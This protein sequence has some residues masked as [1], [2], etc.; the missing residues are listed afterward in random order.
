MPASGEVAEADAR[1]QLSPGR[2]AQGPVDQAKPRITPCVRSTARREYARRDRYSDSAARYLS[3]AGLYVLTP[4][5]F[6]VVAAAALTL[7]FADLGL[8]RG[9]GVVVRALRSTASRTVSGTI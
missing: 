8:L 1:N 4:Q 7:S 2:V 6:A 3:E 5:M 9:A